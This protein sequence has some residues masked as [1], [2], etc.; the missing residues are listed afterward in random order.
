ML[1]EH[2][3]Y[4]NRERTV[5][6]SKRSSVI[7]ISFA[8]KQNSSVIMYDRSEFSAR[9]PVTEVQTLAQQLLVARDNGDYQQKQLQHHKEA[10]FPISDQSVG[11][12]PTC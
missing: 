5:G 1:K 7:E 4:T 3:P 10:V 11:N 9:L 8:K 2:F 12:F 6:I